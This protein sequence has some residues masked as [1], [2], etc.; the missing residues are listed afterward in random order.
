METCKISNEANK[1]F[2]S[3]LGQVLFNDNGIKSIRRVLRWNNKMLFSDMRLQENKRTFRKLMMC[4]KPKNQCGSL[5][6]RK[7]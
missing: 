5:S 6:A 1:L 7:H 4:S 2:L 3:F